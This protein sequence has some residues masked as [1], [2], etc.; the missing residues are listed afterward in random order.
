MPAIQVM[1]QAIDTYASLQSFEDFLGNPSDA[2]NPF[3]FPVLMALD[4]DEHFPHEQMAALS[5]WGLSAYYVPVELEGHDSCMD[6]VLQLE[7]QIMAASGLGDAMRTLL[8]HCH[9]QIRLRIDALA[10]QVGASGS[11][12]LF[13]RSEA[14]FALAREYCRLHAASACCHAWVVNQGRWNPF[15]DRADWLVLALSRLLD[16]PPASASCHDRTVDFMN[17]LHS[18]QRLFSFYPLVLSDRPPHR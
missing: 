14:A 2:G 5:R 13:G 15:F 18:Q 7:Q 17:T 8:L 1:Q 3:S 6:G 9:A 4:E 11:Q 16:L 12:A 10:A